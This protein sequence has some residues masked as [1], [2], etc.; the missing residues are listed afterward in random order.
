VGPGDFQGS[1]SYWPR[2]LQR[3]GEAL[4]AGDP[5]M[6]VQFIDARD[7][8]DWV[9]SMVE[10]GETG[11]YNAA[12]PALP[13][14]L[15]ELLGA[16]R[17]SIATPL[18]LTWVP[19]SWLVERDDAATWSRVLWWSNAPKR[20]GARTMRIDSTRAMAKGLTFRPVADTV[21]DTLAR[22]DAAGR[23]AAGEELVSLPWDEYLERERGALADWHRQPR[24]ENARGAAD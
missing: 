3:G 11:T 12:G 22:E 20:G 13:M 6:Q 8:A 24:K 4:V 1:L 10:G 15:A 7:L 16:I 9:L 17:G 19:T 2:R 21:S 18:R 5:L 14:G 23:F